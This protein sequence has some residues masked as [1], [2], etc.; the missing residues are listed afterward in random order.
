MKNIILELKD[1]KKYYGQSDNLV[2]AI[3]GIDLTIEKGSFVSILG[4][5]G[6]GKTTLIELMSGILMPTSGEVIINGKT[7]NNLEEPELTIMRR[8]NIGIV[9][10]KFNLLK[11][12]TGYE[13]I[14]LPCKIAHKNIDQSYLNEIV[15]QLGMSDQLD[16]YPSQMSG[17]QQQR[18]AIARAL[19]TKPAVLLADEPTGSLDHDN[20][21]KTVQL[22]QK[23]NQSLHQTIIMITHNEHL[24]SYTDRTIILEDGHI[25]KDMK[26]VRD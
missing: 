4:A 12:L 14:V 7:I 13:N 6:S 5:S 1:L 19:I 10:Q 2:K 8:E 15:T 24:T 21:I 25:V 16:K 18:I 20:S 23:I 22:L 3:D 11:M 17:G 26:N 9:F